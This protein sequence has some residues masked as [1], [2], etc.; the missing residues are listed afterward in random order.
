MRTRNERRKMKIKRFIDKVLPGDNVPLF[1][2]FIFGVLWVSLVAAPV[3][4]KGYGASLGWCEAQIRHSTASDG[5]QITNELSTDSFHKVPGWNGKPK[6][7]IA[8][9]DSV[10]L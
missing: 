6:I 4:S 3:V 10:V 7:N 8:T 1:R 2:L 9:F 5:K